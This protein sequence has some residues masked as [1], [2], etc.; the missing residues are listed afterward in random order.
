MV[1]LLL[2]G[3]ITKIIRFEK[4]NHYL[5]VTPKNSLIHFTTTTRKDRWA[6]FIFEGYMH[7]LGRYKPDLR[8]EQIELNS[9]LSLT[10]DLARKIM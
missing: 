1:I 7:T 4:S 6:P 10:K 5:G 2:Q 9:L 8:I 3:R